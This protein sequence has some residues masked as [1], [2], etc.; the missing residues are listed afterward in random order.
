M[1]SI[2][3]STPAARPARAL[4]AAVTVTALASAL[5][6]TACAVP[7]TRTTRVY[8]APPVYAAVPAVEYGTVRRI[9]VID[10]TVQPTGGGVA[11]GALIGGVVGNQ[12]GHGSGRAAATALGVFG[13]A[14]IGNNAEQQQAAAASSR[15]YHVVVGFDDGRTRSFDYRAL[16]GLRTGERVRLEGGVLLRG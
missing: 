9:E 1:T 5:A 15:V 10:T 3:L 14:V 16:D 6:L 4:R 13:G 11:L 12:F 7:V 8:D 2:R